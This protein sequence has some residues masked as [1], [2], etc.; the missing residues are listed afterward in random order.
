MT[1]D[2][3]K[4]A[5]NGEKI[6]A[7]SEWCIDSKSLQSWVCYVMCCMWQTV[8]HCH[9]LASWLNIPFTEN[10]IKY[11]F[12]LYLFLFI[13]IDLFGF[14]LQ[15]VDLVFLYYF[16]LP[17]LI[18]S[19]LFFC[20]DLNLTLCCCNDRPLEG[21]RLLFPDGNAGIWPNQILIV[22]NTAVN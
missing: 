6:W 14:V 5:P 7:S 18:I 10:R 1:T 15:Q 4:Y 9:L 11:I 12:I 20:H 3:L 2:Y 16:Y 13:Q 17:F 22:S 8:Q 21:T 19:L